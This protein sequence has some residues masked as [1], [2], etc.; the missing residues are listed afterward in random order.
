TSHITI[1]LC[2]LLIP[3]VLAGMGILCG[4]KTCQLYLSIVPKGNLINKG[5]NGNVVRKEMLSSTELLS[6]G[7]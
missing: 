6:L 4:Y 5:C 1:V 2:N 3:K 7:N